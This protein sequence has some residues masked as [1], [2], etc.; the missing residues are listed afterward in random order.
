MTIGKLS[1]ARKRR[2]DPLRPLERSALMAK[3]RST[4]NRSTEIAVEQALRTRRISGWRKQSKEIDGTPDFFFPGAKLAIFVHG[5][6]WHGCE[7]CARNTPRNRRAFWTEKIQQNRRRDARVLRQLRQTGF[8]TMT[9][10]EHSL[11]GERWFA[12]LL[13][14]LGR[15]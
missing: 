12:R 1:T 3:V 11:R 9:I 13:G 15:E 7:K 6:F 5:C 8:R 10:W 14:M 4:G 2:L